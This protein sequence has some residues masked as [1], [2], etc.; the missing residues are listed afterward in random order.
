MKYQKTYS[1]IYS[2]REISMYITLLFLVISIA[3]SGILSFSL[4]E[5]H[6]STGVKN[7]TFADDFEIIED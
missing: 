2:I 3:V 5:S 1:V 6:K 7:E 4:H